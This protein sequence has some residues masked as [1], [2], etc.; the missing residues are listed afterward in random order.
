ME[1]PLLADHYIQR[2]YVVH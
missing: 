2:W 1:T